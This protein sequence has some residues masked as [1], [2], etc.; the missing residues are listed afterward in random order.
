MIKDAQLCKDVI[1]LYESEEH[2]T[3]ANKKYKQALKEGK[4]D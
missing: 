2:K 3:E 1:E 4:F